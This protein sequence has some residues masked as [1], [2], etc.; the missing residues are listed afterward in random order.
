MSLAARLFRIRWLMRAPIGMFRLGLGFLF[1]G[2]LLLVEHVG[3][4]SGRPRFAV[5]ETVA[6]PARNEI[7]IASGHGSRAQWLQN[8][9]ANP[10]CFVSIGRIRRAPATAEVLDSASAPRALAGYAREHPKTWQQLN[11]LMKELAGTENPDIPVVR[12]TLAIRARSSP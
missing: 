3:R 6:R 11:R 4:A 5:L 10:Q 1:G 9:R 2:R 7:L 8:L 12:L